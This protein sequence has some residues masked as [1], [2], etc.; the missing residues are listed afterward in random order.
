MMAS[1]ESA[2][3]QARAR[4]LAEYQRRGPVA[5]RLV[6]FG[7]AVSALA[8]VPFLWLLLATLTGFYHGTGTPWAGREVPAVAQVGDC[9]RAGP[10]SANG[11]G[12]W[13]ECQVEVKLAGGRTFATVVGNSMVTPADAG[14]PVEFRAVCDGDSLDCS[15][16]RPAPLI[17]A[18][19]L[20]LLR[21]LQWAVSI[22][23]ACFVAVSLLDVV[24]GPHRY[25]AIY[26]RVTGKKK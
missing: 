25:F 8:L 20:T 24:I 4:A 14:R 12:N 13:W 9:R 22:V 19:L 21:M 5:Y 15:V 1:D 10:V 23:V 11:F 17:W 26:D 16:G 7:K 6:L 3:V 18:V 2:G